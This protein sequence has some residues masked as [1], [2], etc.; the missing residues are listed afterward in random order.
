M[1]NVCPIFIKKIILYK[2]INIKFCKQVKALVQSSRK[3]CRVVDDNKALSA[4]DV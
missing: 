2:V 1:C 4:T 3:G